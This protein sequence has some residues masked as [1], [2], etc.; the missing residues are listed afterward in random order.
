MKNQHAKIEK[1]LQDELNQKNTAL[2]KMEE[3]LQ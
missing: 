3:R 2:A 1:W